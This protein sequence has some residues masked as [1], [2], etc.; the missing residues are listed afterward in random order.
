MLSLS[1]GELTVT[2]ISSTSSDYRAAN[3]LTLTCQVGSD[4]DGALFYLWSSTCS[5]DCFVDGQRTATVARSAL[6]AV[7][8]GTHTCSVTDSVGNAGS[9]SI[10]VAVTGMWLTICAVTEWLVYCL[11]STG[12]GLY[13]SVRGLVGNNSMLLANSQGNIGTLEC[14][15]GSTTPYLGQWISPSGHDITGDTSDPFTVTLGD[16]NNPGYMHISLVPG[17]TLSSDSQGVYTCI[18]LDETGTEHQIHVGIYSN[19]FSSK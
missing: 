3:P 1:V 2:I 15:S 5:G 7:D 17:R 19:G 13:S 12:V 8:S 14:I 16:Q 9:A 11:Y 18:S 4:A 10:H 6:R